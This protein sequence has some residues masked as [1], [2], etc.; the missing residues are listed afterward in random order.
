MDD[1]K[2]KLDVQRIVLKVRRKV[3][4][5]WDR[6]VAEAVSDIDKTKREM[7]AA[8]KEVKRHD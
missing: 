3:R 2:K 1:L 4:D 5:G 6:L 8:E 7:Y